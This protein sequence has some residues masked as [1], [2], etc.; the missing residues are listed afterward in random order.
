MKKTLL[1]IILLV[2]VAFGLF[3]ISLD[4]SIAKA[5]QNNKSLLMAMEDVKKAEQTYNDV[6]G[7]LLPQL[8]LQGAYG[9]SKTY[10]PPSALPSAFSVSAGLDTT[11]TDNDHYLAAVVEGMVSSMIPASPSGEGSFALQLKLDQ[12]LFLGGKLIN[13]IRAVD[14]YRSVQ[15]LRYSLEEQDVVKQTTELFYQCLLAK[16]LWEVQTEGLLIANKHLAR[17]ELFSQEGQVSEFDVLRARLEVAKLQPQVLQ[18]ENTYDLALAA[19]RKQIGE[20]DSAAVPEGDF[21]LPEKLELSLDEAT[22]KGLSDRTELELADINSQIMQIRYNAEKG[23][24]LPNVALSAD[25]SLFTAADDYGI[26]RDDFG[27]KYGLSIGFQIPLFTGF[28]NTSKRNYAKHDYQQAKLLQRDAEELISLQ[29]R[30]DHQKLNH[31]W[32]NYDVQA[33]NIKLAERSL[34]LA[35]VRYDNQVGIQL[36]V[37]DAQI[38]LQAIK[39]QYYQSIYEIISA[40][41]NLKKSL[42]IKL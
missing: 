16:K 42:G 21:T 6:R 7:S 28:S 33:E 12:V 36:E 8:S 18:A 34:Q 22:R 38:M 35:Q 4:E 1:S 15:K 17:A 5:R 9:L 19:F 27:K 41:R 10:L 3:G 32:Q 14:R 31:A 30:Q 24:Y 25:Y 39:L 26:Q 37:F 40:D 23:N 20:A 13:G 2:F 11:A 29:I